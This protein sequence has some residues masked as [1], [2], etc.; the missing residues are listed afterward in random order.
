MGEKFT[1]AEKILQVIYELE[2]KRKKG[3]KI[4]KEIMVIKAWEMFPSDFSMKG[5]P[6]YP[7][8]D[9]SKYLT[10]LFR[11]NLLKGGFFDYK[12]TEKGKEYV[13]NRLKING[14]VI[15]KKNE[16]KYL[17]LLLASIKRQK[18]ICHFS[19]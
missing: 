18:S 4:S 9:F 12:I 3:E 8:A 2:K 19:R 16:E 1:R 5:Y 6:Q 11:R 10:S 17:P 15:V 7:N 14:K 13:E